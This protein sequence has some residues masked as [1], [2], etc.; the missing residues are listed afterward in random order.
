MDLGSDGP[1]F[2]LSSQEYQIQ[3]LYGP[4][5]ICP[6]T[7]TVPEYSPHNLT[8]TQGF[9]EPEEIWY[10]DDEEVKLPEILTRRDAGQ[11][12]VT[13]RNSNAQINFTVD[14]SVHYP[15]SDIYDLEDAVINVGDTFK[16]KCSSVGAPQPQYSWSYYQ[17]ADVKK[18]SDD[19]VSFLHIHNATGYNMGSYTC[20]AWNEGGNIS[21]TVKVTVKG[22]K[23]ECPITIKPE[24]MVVQYQSRRESA[25]CETNDTTNLKKLYWQ[26]A[27]STK[28]LG[29]SWLADPYN[30][31]DPQPTCHADF[32]GIG[33]CQKSLLYTLY[34]TPDMVSIHVVD[35]ASETLKDG[36]LQLQCDIFNVA[37]AQNLTVQWIWI[38]GA[39]NGTLEGQNISCNTNTIRTPVNVTCTM[40]ITLNSICNRT[41]VRCEA[42][43]D[44][45]P[46]GPLTI[47]QSN[48]IIFYEPRIKTKQLPEKVPVIRGYSETLLCEA[49]G[50]PPPKVQWSFTSKSAHLNS[51]ANLTV[52]EPGLYN[53]TATNALNSHTHMVQVI[54]KEDY[55]PLIAGFVAVTVVTISIIFLFI[56]SIYYK[57]TKMRRYSLKNPKLSTHNGN[58]AHN[59]W[60]TQF[61]MTK[62][63]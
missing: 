61:P 35:N 38:K 60:D 11:Y 29:E 49:D 40:D 8:C 55:L 5:Q 25:K 53:C 22:A 58:V 43:L 27:Q 6:S 45:G 7:Y 4:E 17:V 54:L 26:D 30:D 14:I 41:E 18:I 52:L 32:Q 37:P 46:E 1:Q 3:V 33:L 62:L 48:S 57:N 28:K 42:K 51:D 59:G 63:S 24:T 2:N 12:R 13:A 47:N 20:N 34:K 19:G 23:Q 15:P 10:K 56:Y 39:D 50:N 44:L 16:L 21:K 9:P 36:E 31:W